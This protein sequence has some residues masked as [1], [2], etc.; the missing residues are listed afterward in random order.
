MEGMSLE[1]LDEGKLEMLT[2]NMYINWYMVD[3]CILYFFFFFFETKSKR[4]I[5]I[6]L[7]LCL[8]AKT[9]Y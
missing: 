5:T 2:A 6:R 8:E 4:K 1:R 7:A 9:I 3:L